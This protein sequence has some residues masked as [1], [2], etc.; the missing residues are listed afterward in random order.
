MI[1]LEDCKD[2]HVYRV[3]ARN[4]TVAVFRKAAAGFVGLRDKGNRY[5][6]FEETHREA[7]APFG[8][9]APLEEL[10]KCPVGE[11]QG[12]DSLVLY[13]KKMEAE[14]EDQ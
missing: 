11:T 2:G 3:V 1:P 7:G 4:F 14:K 5:F 12:D 9:V 8:T 6:L 10:G 13:L